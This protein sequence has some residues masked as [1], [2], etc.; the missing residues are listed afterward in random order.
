VSSTADVGAPYLAF[1]W[2]DVGL[3]DL[4]PELFEHN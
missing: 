1:F 3:T 4:G 2:R